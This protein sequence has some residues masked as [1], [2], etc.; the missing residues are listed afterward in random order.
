[1][2]GPIGS[3][4]CYTTFYRKKY[5]IEIFVNCGCWSSTIDEFIARVKEIHSG[6]AH[7]V[8]YL[9]ACEYA[10]TIMKAGEN[11]H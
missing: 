11:A 8:A 4:N 10:K 2:V 1:V 5:N 6:T 7:E 9:A 3:R